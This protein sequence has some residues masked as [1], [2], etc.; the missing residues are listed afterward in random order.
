M[1]HAGDPLKPLNLYLLYEYGPDLRPHGSAYIRLIRPLFHPRLSEKL[2]ISMGRDYNGEHA[3]AVIIDRL[4]RPDVSLGV[5]ERLLDVVRRARARLIYSLDDNFL[6]LPQEYPDRITEA[7]LEVVS[8]LLKNADGV[9]VTTP[10]LME[11]YK[12]WNP[13]IV[14]VPPALDERLLV[15]RSPLQSVS[16]FGQRPTVIGYMGTLT[17]D[18]DLE[19]VL[20]ALK[21]TAQRHPAEVVFEI[22]GA[23]RQPGTLQRLKELPVRFIGPRP[24]EALY[25][26]FMLWFTS[27]VRWDVAICPLR[28]SDF[29]YCKSDIKHLDYSAVGAVGLYSKV[30]PYEASVRHMDTGWLAEN[31]IDAWAEGLEHLLTEAALRERLAQ[32]AGHSLY[33][34]RILFHRADDL[35]RAITTLLN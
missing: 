28:C 18:Q 8:Y 31:D 19:M 14:V 2:A 27:H 4:W 33:R 24:E 30:V 35:L 16:P 15:V 22:I 23:V 13:N 5:V 29:N 21:V 32:N 26:L 10:A 9:L 11:R 20:P 3:D 7:E 12:A 6:D 1:T 25:P 34:E 17:H